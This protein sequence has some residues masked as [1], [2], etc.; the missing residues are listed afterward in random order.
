M[1]TVTP[2]KPRPG[3][4]LAVRCPDIAAQWDHQANTDLGLAADQVSYASTVSV[5]WRC[6][7]GHRWQATVT[8]RVND[9]AGCPI[10]S[11][12]R[13]DALIAR[14]RPP[15]PEASLALAAP[16]AASLWDGHT[17]GEITTLGRQRSG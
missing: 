9:G 17:N 5:G 10:C 14:P 16:Q 15:R 8:R 7:Q 12:T 1:S 11:W 13:T 4:S 2:K 3:Q 6:H